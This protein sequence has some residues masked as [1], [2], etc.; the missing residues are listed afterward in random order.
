MDNT[1]TTLTNVAAWIGALTGTA[2]LI[3]QVLEY[4][5]SK[6][7]ITCELDNIF[8]SFWV[9]G[10]ELYKDRPEKT[11]TSE[12]GLAKLADIQVLSINISNTSNSPITVNSVYCKNSPIV[13]DLDVRVAKYLPKPFNAP[14]A[15]EYPK[16]KNFPRRLEANDSFKSSLIAIT[17]PSDLQERKITVEIVT[18]SKTYKTKVMI[19][20]ADEIL[21]H[22][23]IGEFQRTLTEKIHDEDKNSTTN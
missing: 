5:L 19:K 17:D 12:E 10:A 4:R 7:K 13:R 23:T 8:D 1:F 18:P 15:L 14:L 9:N 6:S 11:L 2:S 16:R 22:K 20:N 3:I 21:R